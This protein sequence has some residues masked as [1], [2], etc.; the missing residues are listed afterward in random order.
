MDCR[1]G[2]LLWILHQGASVLTR[3]AQGSSRMR[4]RKNKIHG[5]KYKGIIAVQAQNSKVLYLLP[6]FKHP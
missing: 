1:F 5:S 4:L 6:M 2:D 3:L